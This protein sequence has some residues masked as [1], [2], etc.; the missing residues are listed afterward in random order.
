MGEG[1][2]LDMP[3]TPMVDALSRT[4]VKVESGDQQVRDI[5]SNIIQG[6]SPEDLLKVASFIQKEGL[7]G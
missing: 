7:N 1:E 5:L 2:I 4:E 6:L 3:L